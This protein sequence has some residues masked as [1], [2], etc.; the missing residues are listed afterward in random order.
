MRHQNN[1]SIL[2]GIICTDKCWRT[3]TSFLKPSL[4]YI[5][6]VWIPNKK[7]ILE[8]LFSTTRNKLA[9]YIPHKKVSFMLGNISQTLK[10][11]LVLCSTSFTKT[12]NTVYMACDF[13]MFLFLVCETCWVV[14]RPSRHC[15]QTFGTSLRRKLGYNHTVWNPQI[16][17]MLI[18]Q[19]FKK[20]FG[21]TSSPQKSKQTWVG[22]YWLATAI[23]QGV[24]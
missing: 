12:S 10:K 1:D 20:L 17:L 23:L 11:S 16:L 9:V 13:N 4:I 21:P 3:L 22:S 2:L 5:F 24:Q 8:T 15:F 14:W 6:S 19:T 18:Y 7:M